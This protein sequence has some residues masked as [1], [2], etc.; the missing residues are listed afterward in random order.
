M[1]QL[2]ADG[3]TEALMAPPSRIL[4]VED[5]PLISMVTAELLSDAGF[6]VEEAATATEAMAKLNCRFAAAIIDLGLPDRTGDVLAR[7]VRQKHAEFPIL[8][9]SGR[10][11]HEV[12]AMFGGDARIGYV[13][14]PYDVDALVDALRRL[15]VIASGA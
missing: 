8:I 7:E 2:M 1:E 11:R 9:A 10:G 13:G 12:A 3:Q 14:K 4:L 5:E 6:A 15:G